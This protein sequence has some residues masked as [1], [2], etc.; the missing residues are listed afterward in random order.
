LQF[1][2]DLFSFKGKF[3]M[4]DHDF[5]PTTVG[6]FVL[7]LLGGLIAPLLVIVMLVNM[8]LDIN[9]SHIV[10]EPKVV[11]TKVEENIKPVAE[12]SVS[13]TASGPHAD[14]GGEEVVKAV[15]V[16]CHAVGALGSPKVGDKSAW[17]PRI[18]QGYETLV[19]HAVVGIRAMPARGGNPD[20]TDV[21]V[22]RAV[23]YMANQSGASFP[24]K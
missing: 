18:S 2:F 20:L 17:G 24:T 5:P 16:A 3:Q 10:D 9:A 12:V 14:K 22:G 23:A 1:F 8:V 6:Q 11:A 21:E 15:C 13:E 19:K 7:A 4:S